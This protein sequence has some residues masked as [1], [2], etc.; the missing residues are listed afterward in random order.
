MIFIAFLRKPP[1][2]T[3]HG[4]GGRPGESLCRNLIKLLWPYCR[5]NSAQ[6]SDFFFRQRTS[7]RPPNQPIKSLSFVSSLRL[8]LFESPVEI[9]GS[10]WAM[11]VIW[12]QCTYLRFEKY[13]AQPTSSYEQLVEALKGSPGGKPQ[14]SELSTHKSLLIRCKLLSFWRMYS[15]L[16]K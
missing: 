1:G 16:K 2:H 7:G 5:E 3:V 10:S 6:S 4:S 8:N 12:L 9:D 14:Q 13:H 15:Q 11:R